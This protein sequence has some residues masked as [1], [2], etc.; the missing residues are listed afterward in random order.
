MLHQSTESIEV[1]FSYSHKDEGLRDELSNH[2]SVLKHQKVI[3]DWHDRKITAGDEWKGVIDERL[4]S[5]H[6]I[7]LLI[8]S[9]FLASDYCYDIEM[10]RALER[11]DKEEAIIVPIILRDCDWNGA[12]FGK[13]QALPKDCKPITSWANRDE[14][15]K[16]VAL[17]IRVVVEKITTAIPLHKRPRPAS[18]QSLHLGSLV[19]QLCD[20]TDQEDDFYRFF[21][22]QSRHYPG[23]PQIYLICGEVRELPDSLVERLTRTVIQEYAHDKWGEQRGVVAGKP[24]SWPDEGEEVERQ[25]RLLARI[26]REF[27]RDYDDLS[28]SAFTRAFSSMIDPVIVLRHNLRAELWEKQEKKL[29]KWYLE[30]WDEVGNQFPKPQFV[31]FLK[32]LYPSRESASGWTSLFKRSRFDRRQ[33]EGK[34]IELLKYRSHSPHCPSLMLKELSCIEW[35]HVK[36]WFDQ[37]NLFDEAVRLMKCAELFRNGK[38]RHLDEIEVALKQVHQEFIKQRG[39]S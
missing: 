7:L 5:A 33:M 8:S 24:I 25:Q 10:T 4:D 15:F 9:D 17:G 28:A 22:R 12:P 1:F 35:H 21:Q 34:L 14:A 29:L 26:F 32:I 38:C 2:L 20:R 27:D 37:Y 19:H 23:W 13:L 3:S 30:F 16:N 18:S 11:H 39:Y 6:V 31:V 36:D